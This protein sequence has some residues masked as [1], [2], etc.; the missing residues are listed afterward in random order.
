MKTTV[1]E[2]GQITIPKKLRQRLGIRHGDVLEFEEENGRL[3]AS[4]Y[5]GDD[6]VAAVYGSM[7][8]HDLFPELSTDEFMD[9]IRGVPDAVDPPGG[10]G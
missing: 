3:V 8:E 1:S 10:A 5:L 4:K 7:R 9:L 2:K 6:P